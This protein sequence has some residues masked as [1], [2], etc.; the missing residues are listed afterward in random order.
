L[1]GVFRAII[2]AYNGVVAGAFGFERQAAVRD[3]GQRVKPIHGARQSR[4]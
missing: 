1:G 3:P 4:Q 2:I